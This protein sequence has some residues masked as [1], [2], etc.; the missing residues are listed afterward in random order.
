MAKLAKALA[1][2]PHSSIDVERAFS[3]LKDI[4]NIK[5][6]RLTIEH[7]EACLLS[8]QQILDVMNCG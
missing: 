3:A 7:Q 1:V 4:K 6:S 5:R 8:C 2:L